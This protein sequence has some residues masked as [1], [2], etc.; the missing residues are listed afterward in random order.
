LSRETPI[1]LALA[2][3][4]CGAYNKGKVQGRPAARAARPCRLH[5]G[6]LRE[7]GSDNGMKP[8]RIFF[9][10]AACALCAALCAC[11]LKFWEKPEPYGTHQDTSGQQPPV[12]EDVTPS[13]APSSG[14]GAK[15]QHTLEGTVQ[16]AG[17]SAVTIR[18]DSGA[19]ISFALDGAQAEEGALTEGARVRATYEGELDMGLADGVTLLKLELLE[20]APALSSSA[21]PV[22]G[23]SITGEVVGAA[24]SSLSVLAEG[25]MV[26]DFD[27]S[28]TGWPTAN[29]PGGVTVGAR[30]TVYY[31]GTLG[32]DDCVVTLIDAA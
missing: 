27:F 16:A 24:T 11:S 8:K 12:Y 28:D 19:D 3:S 13:S 2:F 23:Q 26:C 7:K 29:V 25:D 10:A 5:G 9:A 14:G 6:A 18:Q 32:E 22:S 21:A 30:V 15:A 31:T 4:L 1:F 17:M 20:A